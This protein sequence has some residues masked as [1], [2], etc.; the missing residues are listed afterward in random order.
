MAA[1][2]G[3]DEVV[4]CAWLSESCNLV[5]SPRHE[6]FLVRALAFAP[7]ETITLVGASPRAWST[8]A[9]SSCGETRGI[10]GSV[11]GEEHQLQEDGFVSRID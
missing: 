2:R 1:V 4:Y 5:G 9:Q 3:G 8:S 7:I 10:M 6:A 11:P